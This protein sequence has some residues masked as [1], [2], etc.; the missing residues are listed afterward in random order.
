MKFIFLALHFCFVLNFVFAQ[1]VKEESKPVEE[2]KSKTS[3][4]VKELPSEIISITRTSDD[5]KLTTPS[6]VSVISSKEIEEKNM[7][8]LPD[9]LGET[10]GIMIQ[11]TSYGQ[12]SPFIRGFTG[13]RNLMLIDGIRFNNSVFREGPNQ[14]WSTIDSYSIGKIEVMRGAGSLLYGSDAIGGVV[15]AVTKDFAFK[16]DRNWG[17]SETLRYAS[18]EKSTISRTE[19]GIKVGSSLTISGGF[20]YKD[21]N[22]LKGGSDTGTQ[23]KTGYE[24]LNSDI[25]VKYVF[26]DNS[27]LTLYHQNTNQDD[28]WRTHSTVHGISFNGTKVGDEKQRVSFQDRSLS[29]LQYSKTDIESFVD[30][31]KLGV[32][33]QYQKERQFRIKKD[34]SSDNQGFSDNYLGFFGQAESKTI[35]G[36][37]SYGIDVYLEKV[38]SFLDKFKA[39]GSFDSSDIQGPIGDDSKYQTIEAYI[40]DHYKISES[41]G[42]IGGI[43]YTNVSVDV[44]KFKDP[45]TKAK[46]SLSESYDAIVGS[47]KFQYIPQTTNF[48]NIYAGVNQSFRAPNL[49][50]LTRLDTARSGEI[51]IASPGLDPERYLTFEIGV[52]SKWQK[53]EGELAFFRTEIDD[54]IIRTPTG[55][56]IGTNAVI[57]KKNSGSGF[58]HGVELNLS[59]QFLKNFKAFGY[60]AWQD[61]ELEAYPN[62]TTVKETEP[63]SRMLPFSGLFGIRWQA[64]S[65]KYWVEAIMKASDKQDKLTTSDKNDTQRIPV[66]G[67]PGFATF[68]LRG[69]WEV[70][71]MCTLFAA[72][73]NIGNIDYRIHGSGVNEP[74]LNAILSLKVSY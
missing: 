43:R 45:V 71:S 33:Y 31:F 28:V 6:T 4:K 66:G 8:T 21:Y 38:D 27:T 18:A 47:L 49:S 63:L 12:A 14:Y 55:E 34:D 37:L 2:P 13:F 9:L 16:E 48:Y 65:G 11:K 57:I 62:S 73:E 46:A 42:V 23:E 59:Y 68:G 35:I 60:I 32:S 69:G 54:M 36:D 1:D 30:S 29:Y 7:R 50:D 19:A 5:N 24:E 72:V 39:D 15:N 10:P 40:Q 61:G 64:E 56:L 25:K 51:E 41:F 44:D 52:K 74:G 70:S 53:V 17:A 58:V 67:T 20:T 3:N 22:D 26:Q